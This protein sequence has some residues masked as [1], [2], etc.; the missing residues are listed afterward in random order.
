MPSSWCPSA[1]W[2][3]TRTWA[4]GPSC[5]RCGASRR[6][7]TPG[8]SCATTRPGARSPGVC[9]APSRASR[10][11]A[12]RAGVPAAAFCVPGA[13]F[14]RAARPD[15]PAP[16]ERVLRPRSQTT[17]LQSRVRSASSGRAESQGTLAR[18][19]AAGQSAVRRPCLGSHSN[20]RPRQPQHPA[21]PSPSCSSCRWSSAMGPRCGAGW[22]RRAGG[23]RR[24]ASLG[25]PVQ[26]SCRWSCSSRSTS[27]RPAGRSTVRASSTGT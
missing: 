16:G 8:T 24:S 3:R 6:W 10:T 20:R 12:R 23:E 19:P 7:P 22:T 4:P 27:Q 14:C 21:M 1:A 11:Q 17:P 18:L 9:R 5:G 13:A 15:R 2:A 25:A 26:R